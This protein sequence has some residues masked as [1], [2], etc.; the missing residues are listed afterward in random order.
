MISHW[1]LTYMIWRSRLHRLVQIQVGRFAFGTSPGWQCGAR[2]WPGFVAVA[3]GPTRWLWFKRRHR[4]SRHGA[5]HQG[6]LTAN[7]IREETL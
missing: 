1:R 3:L 2:N 7:E 4:D 5:L 6:W